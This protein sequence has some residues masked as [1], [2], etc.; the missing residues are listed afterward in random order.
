MRMKR[1]ARYRVGKTGFTI[2]LND[3]YQGY[4]IR[5]SGESVA[6]LSTRKLALAWVKRNLKA[7][8]R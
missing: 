8:K 1:G 2:E 3:R 5:C 4:V 7:C 6:E